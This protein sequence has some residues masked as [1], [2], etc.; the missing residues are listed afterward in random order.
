MASGFPGSIDNFTDPLGNSPLTSPDHATLHADVNDA[1]EKIETYMGLVK[2]IP[3]GATNGTVA[4]NGTVTIGSAVSSVTVSGVFSS[5]Y[6]NYKIILFGGVGS[7]GANIR[8]TIGGSTTGYYGGVT[9]HAYATAGP[10]NVQAVGINNGSNWIVGTMSTSIVS[11]QFEL[12]GPNLAAHTGMSAPFVN[13]RTDGS[14]T[15]ATGVHGVS[16]AYTSFALIAESGTM[17]GGQIRIYG[18]RN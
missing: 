13:P 16:T 11:A 8:A 17:T 10:A 9:F 1:V 2:V 7:T 6:D 18:Y 12:Y 3:T 15:Y 4:A 5:L 14:I